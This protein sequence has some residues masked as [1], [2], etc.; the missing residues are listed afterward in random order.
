MSL[1]KADKTALLISHLV[2]MLICLILLIPICI[3]V[4]NAFKNNVDIQTDPLSIPFSRL[5]LDN[6]KDAIHNK[7]FNVFRS[8]WTTIWIT[9]LSGFFVVF[10]STMISYI[11]ARSN[12]KF[13]RGLYWYFLC[14][15]MFPAVVSL[16]PQVL[17][18][19]HAHLLHSIY[20][21]V[22]LN[23]ASYLPFTMFVYVGFIK[24]IS[25]Y[26]DESAKIDGAGT[27]TIFWKII[28]PLLKPATGTVCIFL[29]LWI[30]NDFLNPL[31]IL[32]PTSEKTITT[33]LFYAIG[34]YNTNWDDVFAMII[35]SMLPV[36]LVFVFMQR[37]FMKGLV[38]G[39]VK[40]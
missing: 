1:I 11:I 36:L 19:K 33:G 32:G 24:T 22:I 27:Y 40:G 20:G 9:F 4:L 34:K 37:Y 14:G 28:F 5:T 6:F 18:L 30:W 26:L 2:L 21:L 3:V 17:I 8:Y 13:I 7:N 10:A 29:F 23:V 15:L 12:S 31:I 16:L 25:V 39:A 35:L 38:E